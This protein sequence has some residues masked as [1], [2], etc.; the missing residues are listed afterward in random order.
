MECRRT[1]W[2]CANP[3]Q[4][5]IFRAQP[6]P[7]AAGRDEVCEDA[8]LNPFTESKVY[9]LVIVVAIG[10]AASPRWDEIPLDVVFRHRCQG[11]P[12]S[13]NRAPRNRERCAARP[14]A[15]RQGMKERHMAKEQRETGT[16]IGSDKVEGTAVY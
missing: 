3:A 15:S 7:R 14:V 12:A 11:L 4:A 2:P 13:T 6:A 1:E 16:L 9:P 8:T 5:G 10:A